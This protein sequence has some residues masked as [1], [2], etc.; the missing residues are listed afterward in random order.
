[1]AIICREKRLL[2]ILAPHTASTA[3]GV[4][5]RDELGGEW[6]P[7]EEVRDANG[8]ITVKRKHT[9]LRELLAANLLSA[10]ERA[11]LITFSAVRNPF[12][13]LVSLYLK[14][15]V[16]DQVLLEKPDAWIHGRERKLDNLDFCRDHTFAEWIEHVHAPRWQDRFRG[17]A[18]RL[19][20]W[21]YDKGI[22]EIMRYEHLQD[23]FD[24]VLRKA[25]IA[26][27]HEIPKENVTAV[28]A[29]R[30]YRDFYSARTRRL[31]E[32]AYADHLAKYGY[33]F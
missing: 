27:H 14:H 6:L 16:K 29:G 5:L 17:R 9:T 28:R 24:A 19:A 18:A 13:T 10:D 8:R 25:G 31:V 15:S 32:V 2:F 22:D 1:M 12:D 11:G 26:E 21:P 33:S 30:D 7:P 23:G 4:L 3:I 20:R